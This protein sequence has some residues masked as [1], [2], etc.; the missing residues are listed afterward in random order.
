MKRRPAGIVPPAGA[1]GGDV[2]AVA[3]ALGCEPTEILDLSASFNLDAPDLTALAKSQLDSL[4]RY[5]DPI[6]ATDAMAAALGTTLDSVLLTNGGAEAIALVAGE[7]GRA[8]VAQPEFSLYAR[9][10]VEVVDPDDDPAVPRIRSNPNN[11]TGRLAGADE[12]AAVWDEAFYPLATGSWS[13]GD[14]AAGRAVLAVGSLTKVFACP[15]LRVGYVHAD[16]AMI[17]RLAERQPRWALNGLAAALVPDLLGLADLPAWAAATAR[18]RAALTAAIPG[19]EPSDANFVL[20][21]VEDGAPA[22]RDRLAR[23]GVLVRDCTSFGLPGHIR[24]AVPN[25]AGLARLVA[26]WERR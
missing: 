23:Q 12:T 15:G 7:L 20:V 1:H 5:P 16:P 24:V 2:V 4:G 26:A 9:H 14:V 8:A 3:A 19:V 6:A 11:P 10:L 17:A 22:A 13:R 21:R 18:R 25:E